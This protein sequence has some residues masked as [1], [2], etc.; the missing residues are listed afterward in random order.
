MKLL[1]ILFIPLLLAMPCAAL[2][3]AAVTTVAARF[4]SESYDDQFKARAE[5]DALVDTATLPDRGD[6][7]AAT[8]TL[9]AVLNDATTT[10]EAKKY[11]LRAM[12]R[13]VTEDAVETLTSILK[14][15][16]AM[17]AEEARQVL[18]AIP[19][20]AAS[21][22]LAEALRAAS[23]FRAKA[24]F[25]DSLALQG[26]DAAIAPLAELLQDPDPQHA[27]IAAAA[28][29][30]LGARAVAPLKEAL[31]GG[32]LPAA[33]APEVWRALLIASSGDPKTAAKIFHGTQDSVLK[34]AAF[35]SAT[36]G[37]ENH[38]E[39]IATAARSESAALRH[40]A[41]ARGLE[42]NS[43]AITGTLAQGFAQMPAD[44]RL[45]VLGHLHYFKDAAVAEKIALSALVA[46]SVDE[47][48]AALAALGRM[49]TA[50][51]I[52]AALGALSAREPRINQAAAIA[53]AANAYPEADSVLLANLKD[54][55]GDARLAAI[56]AAP[57]RA[58]PGGNAIL[59]EILAGSDE[60]AA[61]EA[62]KSLYFTA[63]IDDLRTLCA[64][65]TTTEEPQRKSL[66]AA[67]TR[68]AGR[69]GSE[70]AM[71]LIKPLQ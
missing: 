55:S 5:L 63:S 2:D 61:R 47:R 66:V 3:Q 65:A 68:I 49:P 17:L 46:E 51:A 26:S 70:E 53:L 7:A 57:I 14:G 54:G 12:R 4:A 16:D 34:T 24:G 30:K 41:L 8:R 48:I 25:A 59:I 10:R 33:V 15:G 37:A 62:L 44:D 64:K 67:C 18:E 36:A 29:A 20:P 39:L 45:V 31:A 43:P 21:A 52:H 23:D 27:R 58:I 9:C 69:L 6:F 42:Q 28:L 11:L 56:K 50:G 35:L 38:D 71:T 40:T 13:I 22:V 32:K 19:S 1:T 60:E